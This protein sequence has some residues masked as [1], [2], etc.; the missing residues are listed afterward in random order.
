VRFRN[1]Y[2][3]FVVDID[4]IELKKMNMNQLSSEN[5]MSITDKY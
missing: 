5:D 2:M 4:A 3:K 1:A